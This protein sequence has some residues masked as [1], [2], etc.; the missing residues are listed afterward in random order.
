MLCFIGETDDA[1]KSGNNL[2]S[3]ASVMHSF[4]ELK[5]K[6]EVLKVSYDSLWQEK[7]SI[8]LENRSLKIEL[9]EIRKLLVSPNSGQTQP[10]SSS[11]SEEKEHLVNED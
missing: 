3:A 9:D 2:Q 11:E 5:V 10:S 6:Y 1:I 8:L 7:E 4:Q